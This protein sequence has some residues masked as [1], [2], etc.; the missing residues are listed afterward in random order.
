MRVDAIIRQGIK[1]FTDQIGLLWNSLADYYT[2]NANFEK[3]KDIYEEAIQ[4]VT[5]VRDFTQVFD[6]YAQFEESVISGRME[7]DVIMAEEED[8]LDL[9]LEMRLARMEDLMD[10]RPLLLNR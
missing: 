5:T 7:N 9:E 1:R 6:A 8:E 10:R 2:R 3:A 4:T